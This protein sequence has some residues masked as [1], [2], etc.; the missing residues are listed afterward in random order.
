MQER[1]RWVIFATYLFFTSE[2]IASVASLTASDW[3]ILLR[4]KQLSTSMDEARAGARKLFIDKLSKDLRRLDEAASVAGPEL[5]DFLRAIS[6]QT[7]LMIETSFDC[8]FMAG[9]SYELERRL[10]TVK[11]GL[12]GPTIV[13]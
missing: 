5:Q 8:G 7:K 10:E 1:T 3:G 13:Q 12:K 4:G 6:H 2:D 9:V 11:R